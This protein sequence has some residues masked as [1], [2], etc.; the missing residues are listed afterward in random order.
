MTGRYWWLPGLYHFASCA[1]ADTRRHRASPA[2]LPSVYYVDGAAFPSRG[3][4]K[5]LRRSRSDFSLR[6]DMDI[7][8]LDEVQSSVLGCTGM[9]KGMCQY[10]FDSG[11]WSN[12]AVI[13]PLGALLACRA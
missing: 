5:T 3:I 7:N 8:G 10:E 9:W 4:E 11:L 2:A 13:R 12:I 6:S 1:G